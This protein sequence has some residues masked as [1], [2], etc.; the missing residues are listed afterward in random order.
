MASKNVFG[1]LTGVDLYPQNARLNGCVADSF[2]ME[3]YLLDTV[4]ASNLHLLTLRNEQATKNNIKDGFLKH[5]TQAKEGD[6]V[7]IHYAGHGSREAADPVFWH[8]TPDRMNEV[9]VPVDSITPDMRMNNP[10]ADKELKWLIREVAKNNPHIAVILDCCHSGDGTRL[11]GTFKNRF[12][13]ARQDTIRS[14]EEYVFKDDV[15]LY[16]AYKQQQPFEIKSGKH[17]LLAAC[18]NSQTAKELIVSGNKRGIF[19]YGITEALRNNSGNLSYRDLMRLA[20]VKVVNTVQEQVPQLEAVIDA[21]QAD[22]PFLGG[23]AAKRKYYVITKNPTTNV[24]EMDAGQINGIV[25][26]EL[27]P[28]TMSVYA[29]DAN[30]DTEDPK[31]LTEAR[32]TKLELNRSVLEMGDESALAAASYKATVANM[33]LKKLKIRLEVEKSNPRLYAGLAIVRAAMATGG[34]SSRPTAYLQEVDECD[35][36]DYR[37]IAYMHEGIGKYK[38]CSTLDNRPLVEQTVGFTSSSAMALV[39]RLEHIAQWEII[40]QLQNPATQIANGAVEIEILMSERNRVNGK[41]SDF[42]KVQLNNGILDIPYYEYDETDENGQPYKYSSPEIKIRVNNHS[43]AQYFVSMYYLGSDFSCSNE[44][45]Q[46]Y[47]LKPLQKGVAALEDSAINPKVPDDLVNLGVSEDK[48]ILKLLV[49]T[50]DF[51]AEAYNLQGLGYAKSMRALVRSQRKPPAKDWTVVPLIINAIRSFDDSGRSLLAKN[52]VQVNLP[53]GFD[54]VVGISSHKQSESTRAINRSSLPLI[55]DILLEDAESASIVPL[56]ATRGVAP[57]LNVLE[58]N[59]VANPGIITPQNPITITLPQTLSSN[60][61]I[62][63]FATDGEF[64]YPLGFSESKGNATQVTIERLVPEDPSKTE[65]AVRGLFNTVKIVLHK[66]VG[67]KLGFGYEYPYLAAVSVG[68]RGE[69]LYDNDKLKV[70]ALVQNAQR[71]LLFTHG[72]TGETR[73]FL[74]PERKKPINPLLL[75]M[76][77]YYDLILAF[78]YDSYSTGIR[79]TALDL[80]KRLTDA[81]LGDGHGKT[82]HIVAHSMGGLVSRWMIEK[83]GANN[84]VQHLIMLGT[85]N[86]GSPWPKMKDWLGW[87]IT[88]GLSKI[89]LVGWPLMV[90][91][92]LMEGTKKVVAL[93]KVTDDM[94]PGSELVQSLTGSADPH[95]PYTILAGNTS[96][97][98]KT[99]AA[100]EGKARKIFEKLGIEN[101]HYEL[102][103]KLLFR[104]VND[105]AVSKSSMNNVPTPRTPL[106]QS[107]AVACDH[108]T[109]FTTTQGRKALVAVLQK[110]AQ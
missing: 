63:P 30:L 20:S 95:V 82:L 24:W 32:V 61:T 58:L 101:A 42:V 49:S 37:V 69:L 77:Q 64:Y 68:D 66:L 52:G 96:T 2:D 43:E 108:I 67:Q 88:I 4:P 50:D 83:E 102:L 14:F 22:M 104:E 25:V 80:K 28:T 6:V 48:T 39:R 27:E 90:L 46:K 34:L 76:Q 41:W 7:V 94:K 56:V 91:N 8:I 110:L 11:T 40:N 85:P 29:Q 59:N 45:L 51:N 92:Y 81:G 99:D 79:Q 26:S 44:L 89:T 98:L 10:L 100:G 23:L 54:A 106:P 73:A 3:Q 31:P 97:I 65:R 53:Q 18:R 71:I 87:A 47:N 78:D 19:T 9:M 33:P 60:E 12:T 15:Q 105:I 38:I 103:T 74:Q 70:A 57:D 107:V 75:D 84:M 21:S 86:N 17:I 55:P 72:I 36:P 16:Q 93:D 35:E 1:L 109:Y 5:L 62:I 13:S